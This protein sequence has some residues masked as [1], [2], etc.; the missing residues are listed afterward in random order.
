M[1]LSEAVLLVFVFAVVVGAF[2]SVTLSVAR[3]FASSVNCVTTS[4]ETGNSN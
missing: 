1:K 3:E 2:T 4:Y